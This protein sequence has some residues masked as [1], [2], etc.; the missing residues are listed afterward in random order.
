MR[1]PRFDNNRIL[2]NELTITGSF[3]YDADGFPRAL[4]LLASGRVPLDVLVERDDVPLDG[5]LDAALGLHEGR[6]AAKVMVVPRVGAR[7][8]E[9]S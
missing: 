1:R 9:E 6:L 2:L 4:E 3:V 8:R 5:L 7:A